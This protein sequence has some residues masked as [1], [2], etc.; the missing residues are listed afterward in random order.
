ME[1]DET[2]IGNRED[3]D[4]GQC[5]MFIERVYWCVLDSSL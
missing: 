5:F 4:Y 1:D 2:I 3:I